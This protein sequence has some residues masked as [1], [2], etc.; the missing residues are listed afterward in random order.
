M[1]KGKGNGEKKW[2]KEAILCLIEAYKEEPCLYAV[3]SPNYHNKHTRNLALK[4]VCAAVSV[5]KPGITESECATKFHNL[6]N[7]LNIATGKVKASMKSGTGT[8]NVI[9]KINSLMFFNILYN[10]F[11]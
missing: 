3:N 4:N 2:S 1:S 10:N 6:R 7:Q 8:D 9:M 11:V 5:Y